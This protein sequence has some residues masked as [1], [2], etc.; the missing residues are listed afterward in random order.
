MATRCAAFVRLHVVFASTVLIALGGFGASASALT[1]DFEGLVNGQTPNPSGGTSGSFLFSTPIADVTIG[2]PDLAGIA[3][4]DTTSTGPN[5]S[6]P[7]PDLLVDSGIALIVQNDGETAQSPFPGDSSFG[8]FDVPNDDPGNNLIEIAFSQAVTVVSLD[9][10]DINGNGPA[11]ILLTDSTGA[12]RLYD[13][14]MNFT[15]DPNQGAPGIVTLDTLLEA[16]QVGVGP[17]LGN[18]DTPMAFFSEDAGFDPDDVVSVDYFIF[19]SGALDNL[20]IIPEPGTALLLGLGLAAL[21]GR[22][23]R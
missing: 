23:S 12:T 9:V 16:D 2:S 19:G 17:L 11:E 6:G 3:A 1:L 4:F 14:T 10:I 7:D 22:R 21:S 20:V 5:A 15:G 8:I 13:L 18:G